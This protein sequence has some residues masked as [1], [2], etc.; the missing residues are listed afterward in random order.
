MLPYRNASTVIPVPTNIKWNLADT[1]KRH[2]N[3]ADCEQIIFLITEYGGWNLH[4]ANTCGTK[5]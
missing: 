3:K 4:N 2:E 1:L 5:Y